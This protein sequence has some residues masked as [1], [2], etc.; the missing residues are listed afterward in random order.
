MN[1]ARIINNVAVDVSLDPA[2]Q[3]HPV[4]ASEFVE[5]PDTVGRGWLYDPDEDAWTEPEPVPESESVAMYPTMTPLDFKMCLTIQE[6]L[7]AKALAESDP[8]LGDFFS[9]IEDPRL[10]EVNCNLQSVRDAVAYLFGKLVED[11]AVDE[12]D[13]DARI[14]AVLAGTR[15]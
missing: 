1:Y 3:F 7:A 9:I 10:T 13:N 8:I 5:V 15:L 4:I 12:A 6:R 14:A 11:G 2:N